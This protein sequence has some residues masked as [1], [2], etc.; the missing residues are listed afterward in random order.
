MG[1]SPLGPLEWGNLFRFQL[2]WSALF[3]LVAI[4]GYVALVHRTNRLNRGPWPKMRIG[5][6]L[7]AAISFLLAFCSVVG[8]YDMT[9]FSAHMVQHLLLVMVGA[10]LLAASAPLDLL[11]AASTGGFER[12]LR[13]LLD[14]PVAGVLGHPLFGFIL[15]ALAIPAFHLTSLFSL[16][17][18][19]G[20]THSLEAIAFIGIGYLFWRPVVGVENSRHPLAPGLRL[21][22][23][24][25]AVP[26][27]TITGLALVSTNHVGPYS[28]FAT[29]MRN[30]GPTVLS[31]I[32]QGGAIMWIVGD[33]IM[34][35]ALIPCAIVWV[36]DERRQT[37]VIDAAI[38]AGT[39]DDT[40][41]S[42]WKPV[43]RAVFPTAPPLDLEN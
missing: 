12:F 31:D 23:L 7:G 20:F 41:G 14:S 42:P 6:A 36:N 18:Q 34:M 15:Y 27:D 2:T 32:H 25:L 16:A 13:R 29:G 22:Y 8:I 21:V 4:N 3:I 43:A 5:A 17:M 33:L 24:F 38:E 11:V 30:W 35:A 26:V 9:L 40:S 37:A 28:G 19:S 1:D 10:A 39:T